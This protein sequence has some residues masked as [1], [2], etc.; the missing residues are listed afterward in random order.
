MKGV[1]ES[2]AGRISVLNLLGLSR[3]DIAG[4]TSLNSSFTTPFLPTEAYFNS[5]ANTLT[6]G[7]Y[8]DVWDAMF[9]GSLP[10]A[11][12]P[13]SDWQLL[14]SSYLKTYIEREVRQLMN[15]GNEVAFLKFMTAIAANSGQLLNLTSISNHIGM[16]LSTVERWLSIL[17]TSNLVYLLQPYHNNILKRAIK[18]P[19]LYVLDTGLIC[20]LTRWLNPEV[21]EHGAAAGEIFETY[22]VSEIIKS[23]TNAG[24]EPPL[25]FYRD[26]E[27][28][29]IDLLIHENGVLY[30]LEIKKHANPRA[31]DIKAFHV[32]EKIPGITRG[33]GGVI[34]LYDRLVSLGEHDAVIPLD[35]I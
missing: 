13:Q 33:S 30:P 6:I 19:K 22:V 3:R 26:K 18:T 34:C 17:I 14:Y 12:Y 2:L 31:D 8:A 20:Y 11:Q 7:S 24:I 4:S 32:L 1:A 15:V 9:R 25:Y 10:L 29:E 28:N 35:Y 5:R 16:S 21:L 27:Q 23:Y